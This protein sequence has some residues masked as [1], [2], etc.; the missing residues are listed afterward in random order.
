MWQGGLRQWES[1]VKQLVS[2]C[3]KSKC[4]QAPHFYPQALA[5]NCL[6][7]VSNEVSLSV[8]YVH[9]SGL[10]G[11]EG[12]AQCSSGY[13]VQ[14]QLAIA[15]QMMKLA[16][17]IVINLPGGTSSASM[18]ASQ[19]QGATESWL[20]HCNHLCIQ[21]QTPSARGGPFGWSTSRVS[22]VVCTH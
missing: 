3:K 11:H 16:E 14:I 15:L 21:E 8:G 9:S 4:L 2:W 5:L 12:M 22:R 10:D 1:W 13:L 7:Y 6:A 18:Q 19:T 20:C 17:T